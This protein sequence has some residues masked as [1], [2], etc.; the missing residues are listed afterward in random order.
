MQWQYKKRGNI[1]DL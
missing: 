1:P